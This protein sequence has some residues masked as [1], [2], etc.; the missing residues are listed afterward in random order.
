MLL[1]L[2]NFFNNLNAETTAITSPFSK[3]S[4]SE[5]ISVFF[6]AG[7]ICRLS[8]SWFLAPDNWRL[9]APK[10]DARKWS[11]CHELKAY[12]RVISGK[13]SEQPGQG[14][15]GSLASMVSYSQLEKIHQY[16]GVIGRQ[17][18]RELINVT[19]HCTAFV[20]FTDLQVQ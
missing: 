15:S 7:I 8:V 10:T 19:C 11:M 3:F 5:Y 18:G 6:S 14:F 9:L 13:S 4:K 1:F 12:R 2:L 20:C 16:T 17:L